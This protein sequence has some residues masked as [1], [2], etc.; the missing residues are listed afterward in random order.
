MKTQKLP[1]RLSNL[2][3]AAADRG[4]ETSCK[5]PNAKVGSN[6]VVPVD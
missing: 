2:V 4:S 5:V 3:E 6:I 1:E